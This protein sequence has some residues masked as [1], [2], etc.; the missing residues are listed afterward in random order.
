MLFFLIFA[1]SSAPTPPPSSTPSP[2]LSSASTPA[3]TASDTPQSGGH[4]HGAKHGGIQKELEGMH[5]E[6]LAMPDGVMLWVTD[7][8]A[9]PLPLDG[10][11][12]SAVIKGPTGVETTT[13]T[14]MGDHLHAPAK[15]QQGQ[16]ATI[17]VTLT[18]AD[19][20]QSVTYDVP[21]VGLSVHDHTSLH[22]GQVS[23]W[24][25]YHVEYLGKEGEYRFWISDEKRQSIKTGISGS[26]KDGDTVLPLTLGEDG[27]LVAKGE[28]AGSRPV[29]GEFK[30][31][32]TSF[33]LGFN[34]STEAQPR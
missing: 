3:L 26:V 11:A 6:A 7:K 25:D 10:I 34:P 8:D 5:L 16:P 22:S 23:M 2:T 24:K 1:C 20:A 30:V 4:G 17:V 29:M 31:G 12:G 15:L 14:P 19:K 9:K 32:E 13:L 28:G 18:K 21:A 33:S 27:G